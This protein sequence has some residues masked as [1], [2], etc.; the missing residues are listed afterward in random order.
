M[1]IHIIGMSICEHW[2]RDWHILKNESSQRLTKAVLESQ[3]TGGI[4]ALRAPL[5]VSFV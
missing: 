2:V 4:N 3:K 1:R 5:S